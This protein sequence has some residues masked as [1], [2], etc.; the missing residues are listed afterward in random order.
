MQRPL[1]ITVLA[2]LALILGVLGLFGA[3]ILLGFGSIAGP[4]G[5]LFGGGQLGSSAF[6]SG[7]GWLVSAVISLVF[8]IGALR[9]R[10]WAWILGLIDSGLSFASAIWG[11]LQGGSWCL[12]LPG[13]IL[14]AIIFIY[15]LTP[16]VRRAFRRA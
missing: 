9:L 4:I 5:A 10:G 15:L 14:P 13:L 12:S 11:V 8:A 16:G 7:L 3:C 2:I 6:V 1:G